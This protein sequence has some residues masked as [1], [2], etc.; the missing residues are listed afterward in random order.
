M[1]KILDNNHAEVA[2]PLQENEERWYLPLFGVYHPKK[3]EQ[4]R[5]VF[6]SS[7]KF[8][9]LLTGPDLSNSLLGVLVRFRRE[10]IAVTADV[11]HMFHSERRSPKLL[12][13]SMVQR[14]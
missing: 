3:P 1:G 2:P 14:Q 13:I 6:D 5:G 12:E 11:Q 4:I 7:A 9:V 10:M 8:N